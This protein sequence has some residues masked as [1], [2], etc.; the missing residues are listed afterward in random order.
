M[1]QKNSM[2]FHDELAS[3]RIVEKGAEKSVME[4]DEKWG[5]QCKKNIRDRGEASALYVWVIKNLIWYLGE[6][7]QTY[8]KK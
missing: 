5:E 7:D 8:T 4:S 3:E 6:I 1:A 2:K